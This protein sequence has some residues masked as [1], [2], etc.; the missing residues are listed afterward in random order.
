MQ[1]RDFVLPN[2]FQIELPVAGS[3]TAAEWKV[4]G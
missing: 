1:P 2:G 4:V 3:Y